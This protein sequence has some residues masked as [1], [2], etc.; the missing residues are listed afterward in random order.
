MQHNTSR[1]RFFKQAGQMLGLALVAPALFG[2][3]ALAEERRRRSAEGAAPA[4]GGGD[5]PMVEP[6]KGTAAPVNYV[7]KHSD[8]KDAALKV[9]RGGVSF[10]KQFCN[11]CSFYTKHGTKNG[12]ETGKCQ[13]FP[14][15]LVKGTAW[16][17]TWTKKA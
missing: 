4:A 15:Q 2:S 5:L 14:N 8:V 17:S 9:D 13:I 6:G 10:D 3:K 1:R 7:H 11:N 12:E 16:C